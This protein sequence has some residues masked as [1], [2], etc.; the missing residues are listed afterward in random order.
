VTGFN[1]S[2]TE[3]TLALFLLSAISSEVSQRNRLFE[4][5]VDGVED[6]VDNVGVVDAALTGGGW[7]H[8]PW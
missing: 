5:V 3:I 1:F 8:G 7:E 4:G 6:P 2:W